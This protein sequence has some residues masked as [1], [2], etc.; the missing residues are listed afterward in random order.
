MKISKYLGYI[1]KDFFTVFGGLMTI[2]VIY[3]NI[4]SIE[5]IGASLLCEMT[6]ATSAFTLY[7][8]ALRNKFELKKKAQIISLFYCNSWC[9]RRSLCN[10]VYRWQKTGKTAQ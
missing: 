10:D 9:N 6:L 5:T 4:N 8:Y 7:K 3:L 1:L 2:V